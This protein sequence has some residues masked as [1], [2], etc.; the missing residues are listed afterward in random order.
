MKT[1]TLNLTG[2]RGLICALLDAVDDDCA[3]V[4]VNDGL[5][6]EW[7]AQAESAMLENPDNPQFEI[8]PHNIPGYHPVIIQLDSDWFDAEEEEDEETD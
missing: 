6:G 2:G 8:S 1:Y 3:R 5:S 4:I 7:I